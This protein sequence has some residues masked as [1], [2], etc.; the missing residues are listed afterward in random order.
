MQ[1]TPD[2]T[3]SIERLV[4]SPAVRSTYAS[5][6]AHVIA[7]IALA[8]LMIPARL[9]DRPRPIVI[10]LAE[11]TAAGGDSGSAAGGDP[12]EVAVIDSA[13][14]AEEA[15]AAEADVT[16]VPPE[17]PIV[18]DPTALLALKQI[19]VA[20]DVVAVEHPVIAAMARPTPSSSPSPGVAK[21]DRNP[22]AGRHG[23]ARGRGVLDRGGSV[24]SE[25]AV[26]RGLAWLARHQ[27]ADGSWRFDLSNCQCDGG[28]RDPGT[29][30]STTAATGIALLPFL[31]AGHTHVEG[32]YRETV[33]R[34]M[35]YLMSRMQPTPR[36]GDLSEGTM[37]GHG[38][39][40]LAL[41]ESLGMTQD[42]GL[43]RYVQDAV[44]FIETAQDMHGGGWRY[45]P[46]QPGDTTV[47]AWQLAA[48]RSAGL[49]GVAIPSP[50]MDGISRFLDRVQT[51]KGEAYGYQSPQARPCTS[52]VGLLCRLYTGW[53]NEPALDRGLAALAKGGPDPDAVYLN[54]YLS[55]ALMQRDHSLWPRWNGRN[56]DQLVSRQ[57]AVGHE[58][59][60]WFFADHDTAPGGR[61]AHTAL[62]VLTLE[63]YYRLLPI[64]KPEA[65]AIG[66]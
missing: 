5:V 62:A 49:A 50:T 46:G 59:G 8:L 64:Y 29:V 55:Q 13:A 54:F 43:V 60:S 47:T 15:T 66:W 11:E 12:G 57:A 3:T 42:E 52:A 48:L 36:G 38:V 30:S 9:P 21:L 24:A 14:L 39:A 33:T 61:L 53:Q 2:G 65:V 1:D 31:G 17:L 56:R 25:A 51:R 16:A 37:Y 28:C 18:P 45:L 32:A 27:A 63:V 58:M 35:Y 44:R 34:G 22:F 23:R 6:I 40:T 4:H 19:A 10:G 20:A 41:A 7:L 26:E